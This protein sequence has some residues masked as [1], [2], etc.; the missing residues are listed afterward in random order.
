MEYFNNVL[1]TFLGLERGS[2]VA[3]YAGFRSFLGTVLSK[4]ID[5]VL[6]KWIK[7]KTPK[8][9]ANTFKCYQ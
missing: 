5:T 6:S 8:S 3:I 7:K 1:T 4:L 2:S 9:K